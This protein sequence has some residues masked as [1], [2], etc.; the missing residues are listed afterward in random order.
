MSKIGHLLKD[1]RNES[2]PMLKLSLLNRK[3]LFFYP[4][5]IY[6]RFIDLSKLCHLELK[7]NST[8]S[9]IVIFLS[10]F[11]CTSDQSEWK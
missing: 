4:N 8:E 6:L 7:W 11:I 10:F 3:K 1:I 5:Y 2:L 9:Q